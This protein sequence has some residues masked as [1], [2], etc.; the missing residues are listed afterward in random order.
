MLHEATGLWVLSSA[1]A[2]RLLT[3][4]S[5]SLRHTSFMITAVGRSSV[6]AKSR[7]IGIGK[8]VLK[9]A[10]LGWRFL[11]TDATPQAIIA[12]MADNKQVIE[13][14]RKLDHMPD[15]DAK[16]LRGELADIKFKMGASRRRA[17]GHGTRL[18]LDQGWYPVCSAKVAQ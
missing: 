7:T 2:G 9:E 10:G 12:K 16:A 15:K 18:N 5:K 17:N 11:P 14:E 4:F 6:W 1:A 8:K 3:Y 13:L